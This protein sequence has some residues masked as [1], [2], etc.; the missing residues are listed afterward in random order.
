M[1]L[2]RCLASLVCGW[3][4]G[5]LRRAGSCNVLLLLPLLLPLLLLLLPLEVPLLV[6][7]VQLLSAAEAV[8]VL[9]TTH[10]RTD[11]HTWRPPVP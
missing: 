9:L 11:E 2:G 7:L 10:Q 6:L 8:A 4:V 3:C 1:T 5:W